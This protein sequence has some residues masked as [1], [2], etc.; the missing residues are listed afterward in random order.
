[1]K[2]YL[3]ALA[4]VLMALPA[5]SQAQ[6]PNPGFEQW[7]GGNPDNWYTNNGQTFITV[8]QSAN[9]HSGSS[10][11]RGEVIE[12][13]PGVNLAPVLVSGDSGNGF[14]ISQRWASVRG[15]YEFSPTGGD[16]FSAIVG[17]LL[18]DSLIAVGSYVDSATLTAY[19]EFVV[20]M[21]YSSLQ[22]PDSALITVTITGP[23]GSDYHAGSVMYVDDLS[24]SMTTSVGSDASQ[25]ERRVSTALPFSLSQNAP[26][27]FGPSTTIDFSL[28]HSSQVS[29]KVF[30]ALGEEV[31]TLASGS[32]PSGHHAVHWNPGGLENG[33]YIYQLEVGGLTQT[34]KLT[35][36]R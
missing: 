29:L 26:N 22:T 21:Y 3:F 1:M 23:S 31:A 11:A 35:L 13:I 16:M 5:L 30:N 18:N 34:R 20:N 8:T 28:A 9:A 19:Q 24:L 27:P 32:R 33:V 10:A 4:A 15:F 6:I 14:P 7:T 2:A 25:G 17:F 12:I 36:L